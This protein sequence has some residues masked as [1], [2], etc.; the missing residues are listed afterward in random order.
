MRLLMIIIFGTLAMSDATAGFSS[1]VQRSA[2]PSSS[3]EMSTAH[4]SQYAPYSSS[5]PYRP[6]TRA[7]DPRSN[8]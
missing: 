4:A 1:N 5:G 3:Y 8:N 7:Q 6:S 2:E